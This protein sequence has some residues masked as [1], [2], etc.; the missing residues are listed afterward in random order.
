MLLSNKYFFTYVKI[1]QVE[2]EL[3][4]K[5]DKVIETYTYNKYKSLPVKMINNI[6]KIETQFKTIEEVIIKFKSSGELIK[7]AIKNKELYIGHYWTY[8]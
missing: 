3:I 2:Q 6:T 8:V 1:S 5:Y 4:D 7:R